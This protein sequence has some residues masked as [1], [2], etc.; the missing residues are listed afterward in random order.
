MTDPRATWAVRGFAGGFAFGLSLALVC[1][2]RPEVAL[3]RGLATAV[4]LSF[5]SL[6]AAS[7]NHRATSADEETA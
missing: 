7:L 3:L 4:V 5:V 1:H 2:A 6:V